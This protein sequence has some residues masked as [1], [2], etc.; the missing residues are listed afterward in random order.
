[1]MLAL[2]VDIRL[3][4]SPA[5]NSARRSSSTARRTSSTPSPARTAP[6]SSPTR[7]TNYGRG[8]GHFLSQFCDEALTARLLLALVVRGVRRV[9]GAQHRRGV[10]LPCHLLPARRTGVCLPPYLEGGAQALGQAAA[11]GMVH[12]AIITIRC[13][14]HHTCCGRASTTTR[15]PTTSTATPACTS[16]R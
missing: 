9:H 10:C 2:L 7:S 4:L 15:R 11:G 8:G 12:R 5:R 13:S 14:H 16:S 1:M 3:T 6:S